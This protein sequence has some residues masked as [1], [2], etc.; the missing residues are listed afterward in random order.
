MCIITQCSTFIAEFVTYYLSPQHN[1][2]GEYQ[3][4]RYIQNSL[5]NQKKW[6]TEKTNQI[7]FKNMLFIY[8][9]KI[10]GANSITT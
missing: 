7:T 1:S 4:L 6:N 3:L 10:F 5:Q 2:L 8:R 9:T